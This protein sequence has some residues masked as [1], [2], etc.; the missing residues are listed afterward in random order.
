MGKN[1]L[2]ECVDRSDLARPAR[3]ADCAVEDEPRAEKSDA[4]FREYW[5]KHCH[6]HH[7]DLGPGGCPQ[8]IQ[9]RDS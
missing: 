3:E 6:L 1:L 2:D 8:C 5:D 9:E 4:E 7:D